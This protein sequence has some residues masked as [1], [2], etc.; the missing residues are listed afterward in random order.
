MEI[1]TETDAKNFHG[2][3][4]E[5]TVSHLDNHLL[6]MVYI[7]QGPQ[8]F[9]QFGMCFILL[10]I[11]VADRNG[12]CIN[13]QARTRVGGVEL[14]IVNLHSELSYRGNEILKIFA[15]G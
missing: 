15:F 2:E 8:C 3:I 10:Q 7:F 6:D 11:G 9:D 14:Y 1:V 5:E 13:A 12:D 4:A